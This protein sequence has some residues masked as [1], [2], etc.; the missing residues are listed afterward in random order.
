MIKKKTNY[1]QFG[2]AAFEGNNGGQ[3]FGGFDASSFSDIFEDFFG[4]FT[5]GSSRGSSR[6][7]S[8]NRG[9]DLR[10]DITISLEDAYKGLEK[11]NKIYYI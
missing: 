3:G 4:D 10:Y 11:K 1:D 7:S 6:R 5:G 2:H 8:G 9:N